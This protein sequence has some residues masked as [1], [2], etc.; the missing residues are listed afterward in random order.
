MALDPFSPFQ[1][2]VFTSGL[3]FTY[4][5]ET[6][7]L[8]LSLKCMS[9][10]R[11]LYRFGRRQ[12]AV[13][14]GGYLILNE[15]Q[16][17]SIEI[18]SPTKVE[19]FV[20]WFPRGWAEDAWQ[21]FENSADRLLDS[22]N[23]HF[24]EHLS[25]FEQYTPHDN[26][27]SPKAQRL[28]AAFKDKQTIDDGWLEEQLR[29]LIGSM[30]RAHHSVRHA[31][32]GLDA[33][34]AATREELWRRLTC[35]RDYLHANLSRSIPLAELSRVA[36]LSPFHLLRTFQ[37]A[38]GLTPHQYLNRCRIERAKFLLEKTRIPVTT[39]CGETGFSSLG[40]FSSLF[41]KLCGMS[42]RMWRQ[43]RGIETDE[44]SNIREVYLTGAT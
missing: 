30:V 14:D 22:G 17:Y 40:S 38:F 31:V 32:G 23:N 41:S 33:I 26:E 24:D 29:A 20:L 27:V 28:R 39:I 8:P 43:G 36:C 9:N 25:F 37:N 42:P 2:A 6:P 12:V 19:T 7:G 10:G 13:D 35:A 16:P 1:R 21:T 44:N 34:R 11:A 4:Y 18:A 5:A 3:G 15:G